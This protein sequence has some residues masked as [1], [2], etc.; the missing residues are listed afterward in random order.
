[1]IG[2]NR[3]D[4][5][6]DEERGLSVRR[7]FDQQGQLTTG[8]WLEEKPANGKPLR[9]IYSRGRGQR[10]E[11]GVQ[12]P[13]RAIRASELWQL[14]PSAVIFSALLSRPEAARVRE[15]AD[16]YVV[17]YDAEQTRNDGLLQ[18]TLTLRKSDLH[19]IAQTLVITEGGETYDYRFVEAVFEQPRLDQVSPAVFETDAEFVSKN[20]AAAPRS[21]KRAVS[22]ASTSATAVV[23]ELEVDVAY[24]LDQFRMRFGDQLSLLKTPAG[25][26]EVR[27]VV[28]SDETR[29][30]IAAELSR[31]AT[32]PSAVRIQ[33]DT[34]NELLARKNR[35]PGRVIVSDFV[36]SDQSIPLYAELSRYF[37]AHE[38]S[39]QTEQYRDQLVREFAARVIG[40]SQRAVAHS[41]ELKQLGSRFSAAQLDQFTPSARAKWI[42]LVRNH[43]EALQR[44]LSTLDGELQ[45][46]LLAD[47]SGKPE[48]DRVA[49][50]T[51]AAL[52]SEIDRLHRLV[53]VVDQAVRS[54]FAASSGAVNNNGV[55]GA[56][57]RNG[58]AT[59]LELAEEIG[60]AVAGK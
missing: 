57:F 29:E 51:N 28:D 52:I 53:V 59:A 45:R 13:A 15:T 38:G 50:S 55:K 30:E 16:A 20:E 37:A 47:E 11:T 39:G 10:I 41:L 49:L 3:I 35:Q 7:V 46:I 23:A 14:D 32:D 8:V 31:V 22:S 9:R 1:V 17:A 26:L 43:A 33:L 4:L 34:T 58:L 12:D 36:G 6:R 2:K 44:E 27:G 21:A 60:Q 48:I 24:A 19:P 5:W 56:R 18:A 54:S 40:R 25:V 42:S